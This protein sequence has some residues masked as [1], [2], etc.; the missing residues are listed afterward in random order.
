MLALA[1]TLLSVGTWVSGPH[2]IREGAEDVRTKAIAVL[3]DSRRREGPS[4]EAV[5]ERLARSGPE[6]IDPL[7]D[8]LRDRKLPPQAELERPQTLSEPQ[9]EMILATLSRWSPRAVLANMDARV[10]LD[11]SEQSRVAALY[12][13]ASLGS[14]RHLD[15]VL[16]LAAPRQVD[17]EAVSELSAD[18]ADAL[19]TAVARILRRDDAGFRGLPKLMGRARA[20]AVRPLLFALGDTGDS[21]AVP[22]L[23]SSLQTHPELAAIAI[24]QARRVGAS[25]DESANR[26]LADA[27]RPHLA[28]D[29]PELASAAARTLGE[30]GDAA[31]APLLVELLDSGVPALAESAHWALR[32]LSRLDFGL[33]HESWVAWL[34]S[35][36]QWWSDEAPERIEELVRGSRATRLAAVASV[37]A[38]TWRRHEAAGEVLAALWD[39]DPLLREAACHA[40]GQLGAPLALRRLVE[41]LSDPDP[42]VSRAARGALMAIVGTSLPESPEECRKALHIEP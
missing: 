27:V 24:S 25:Q 3:R 20:D 37:G 31:S 8:L 17:A 2:P 19:R 34:A 40:L 16:E 11:P 9:R 21:C 18:E 26:A 15:H 23:G 22:A 28:S 5:V 33:R 35:E 42:R 6:V 39:N 12:V 1:F 41:T 36:R 4:H 29:R 10:E 32:R 7:L 13:Y 38:R 30:L 14:A